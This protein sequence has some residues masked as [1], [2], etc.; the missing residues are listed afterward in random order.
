MDDAHSKN[1]SVHFSAIGYLNHL[2]HFAANH[3]ISDIHLEPQTDQWRIRCRRDGLLHLYSTLPIN[4]GLSLLNRIKVLAACDI[5]EKRL[6]QDG[7][8]SDK[9]LARDFRVSTCPTMHGEKAVLRCLDPHQN[10]LTLSELGLDS[11][12]LIHLQSVLA[13]PNGL[14][15]VT[16]PT[17]SGKTVTLYSALNR[18][19]A[20]E[21][22]IATIEDPVEML[23]D[24][25][26]QSNVHP[27]AGLTFA[28]TLRALL[29]Q[30]PDILMIGE[31]RDR[32]TIEIAL[33]AAQTGHLVLSTLH[34]NS[35]YEAIIRL[36]Q[37]GILPYQI[38][39][40]IRLIIAQRLIRKR[41]PHCLPR[42]SAHCPAC[43]QGYAGRT[44]I[45]ELLPMSDALSALIQQHP[46]RAQLQQY[47][48]EQGIMNL[49][50]HGLSKVA[51]NITDEQELRRVVEDY[52]A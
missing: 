23:I 33:H 48:S 12:Q 1:L 26:N 37:M 43:Q 30:D 40:S 42:A 6:P 27:K 8:F 21:V 24:G 36:L 32:E 18:L 9:A 2:L 19:Q 34:T 11:H 4:A 17:G 14:I 50:Q 7:G 10:Q 44:G 49:W 22:N 13:K 15:L 46:S 25:I 38:S 3:T 52:T 45:Y 41:C 31:M 35:S 20:M 5:A 51:L 29:R 16:G 39:S 47:Q 28:S